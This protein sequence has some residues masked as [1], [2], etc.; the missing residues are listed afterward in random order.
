MEILKKI[1]QIPEEVAMEIK[2]YIP[3]N[4]LFIT[5]KKYY[6]DNIMK[7]RFLYHNTNVNKRFLYNTD[8]AY[9]S[10]LDSYI[11]FIIKNDFDYVF[12]KLIQYKYNHWVTIKRYK[13]KGMSHCNYLTFLNHLCI[14]SQSTKCRNVIKKI[15]NSN[16]LLRK[17]RHKKIRHINNTWTS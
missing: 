13:Y 3:N 6:G 7:I 11:N 1:D 8:T 2:T 15:E 16:P 10:K 4:V 5:N 14:T 17:K 9:Y 12:K